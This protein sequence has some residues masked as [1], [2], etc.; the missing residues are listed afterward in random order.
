MSRGW[1]VLYL[2][3]RMPLPPPISGV[4]LHTLVVLAAEGADAEARVLVQATLPSLVECVAAVLVE[5][6]DGQTT[7]ERLAMRKQTLQRMATRIVDRG[8]LAEWQR[9][10]AKEAWHFLESRTEHLAAGVR[11]RAWVERALDGRCPTARTLLFARLRGL[12]VGAARRRG[13]GVDEQEDAFQSFSVWLLADG[14]RNLRRW[15]PEGGRSFD[16]W[17]FAR[18]LNQLDTRRRD[19]AAAV[20]SEHADDIGYNEE[21]RFTSRK[22]IKEI[23]HWL[24]THCDEHQYSMF[25]RNVVDQQSATEIAAEMGVQPGVVYTTV[26]R[27]RKALES[28]QAT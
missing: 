5:K 20:T 7:T 1:G 11:D 9:A 4:S 18:A 24:K 12:F 26:W 16:S 25:I 13:L 17:Y 28:L 14:G 15:D 10:P 22:R 21:P 23:D 27:L 19:A 6:E 2:R 8:F 3:A